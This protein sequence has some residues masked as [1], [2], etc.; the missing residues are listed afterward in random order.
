M[1]ERVGPVLDGHMHLDPV[2]GLG[3][4]AAATFARAGGSHLL[5][6]TKPAGSLVG[7]VE[8]A[9][10]FREAF[11]LTCEVVAAADEEL[12]GA[13]WPVLGVH[14]ALIS[15]LV[16]DGHTPEDAAALMR[17][18]LDVAAEYVAEGRALALKS[19]RPHYEVADAV[20]S[21]SNDVMRHAFELGADIGCAVQLHTEAGDRF[22]TVADWA[23]ERGLART[24]VVKHYAE[25]PVSGPVP[26]VIGRTAALEAAARA[27]GPFMMETDFLDD[28]DRPGAVLG[29][30]TVPRR[31]DWLRD[32][33]HTEAVRTAHVETPAEVYG[34][35]TE[36]TLDGT[37]G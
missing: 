32:V 4:E 26:S 17:T 31:V 5:V 2:S 12:R 25:G 33:G 1:R 36:A 6:V 10:S 37:A 19:G 15:R 8:D 16:D 13:A 20:W 34:I 28:P 7:T 30:R 14:P 27:G 11:D 22:E 9:D 18:G 3:A 21:A 23:E 29:P 24:R 35:D